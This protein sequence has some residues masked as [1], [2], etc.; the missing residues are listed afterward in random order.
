MH[1]NVAPRRL[2]MPHVRVLTD[3]GKR[4]KP[5]DIYGHV[6]DKNF[7]RLDYL[8]YSKRHA[9]LKLGA[10]RFNFCR[11]V[12]PDPCFSMRI[13]KDN[14]ALVCRFDFGR[15]I[16]S[17]QPI[18]ELIFERFPLTLALTLLGTAISIIIAILLGVVSAVRRWS[19]WDYLGMVFSQIGMA[20]PSFWLGILLL[21]LL[22]VKVKLF[23]RFG[24]GTA[25]TTFKHLIL[26]SLSLG[27]ASAAVL[28]R[29]TKTSMVE[30]LS[31]EYI[32][33]QKNKQNKAESGI[34]KI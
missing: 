10:L 16:I 8:G 1:L 26:P 15:S 33:N 4:Q 28:L 29:L 14:R 13:Q 32:V 11:N 9:A 7:S 24:V 23:P 19:F 22:S 2:V 25:D 18:A 30:E 31:K 3:L 20:I 27:I 6:E 21:L 5:L 34:V 17:G 12:H